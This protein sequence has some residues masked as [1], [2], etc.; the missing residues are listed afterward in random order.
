MLNRLKTEIIETYKK[1][2]YTTRKKD[3]LHKLAINNAM[4]SKKPPIVI[5]AVSQILL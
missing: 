4:Y 2:G 1:T 3:E 5:N